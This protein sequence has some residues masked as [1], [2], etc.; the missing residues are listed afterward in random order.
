MRLK[1]MRL[2]EFLQWALCSDVVAYND[3]AYID[4]IAHNEQAK[5]ITYN[6]QSKSIA[7]PPPIT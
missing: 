1:E 6:D 3:I 5:S 7:D 4:V 2:V